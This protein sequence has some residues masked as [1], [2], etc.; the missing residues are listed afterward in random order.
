[1]DMYVID[2]TICACEVNHYLNKILT[3]KSVNCLKRECIQ[4][5]MVFEN[6]YT[7]KI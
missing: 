5:T 3:T 1:M 4:D 7:R 6:V 2:V